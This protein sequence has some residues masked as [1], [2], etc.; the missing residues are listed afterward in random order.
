MS[1]FKLPHPLMSHFLSSNCLTFDFLIVPVMYEYNRTTSQCSNILLSKIL[2]ANYHFHLSHFH[3]PPSQLSQFTVPLFRMSHS[4]LF[5]FQMYRPP[6]VSF[7][8]S[9]VQ[10]SRFRLPSYHMFLSLFQI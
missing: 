1:H 8:L 10:L 7:K 5:H 2:C 6:K 9:H 3:M 4:Q